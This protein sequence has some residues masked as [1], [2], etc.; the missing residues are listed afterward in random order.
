MIQI[1]YGPGTSQGIKDLTERHIKSSECNL[2]ETFV[3]DEPFTQLTADDKRLKD[4]YPNDFKQDSQAQAFFLNEE[5]GKLLIF[6]TP[7]REQP[8]TY[9]FIRSEKD[10]KHIIELWPTLPTL[11]QENC[12]P[13]FDAKNIVNPG[14]KAALEF[15]TTARITTDKAIGLMVLCSQDIDINVIAQVAR[16][17]Y[18]TVQFL[19]EEGEYAKKLFAA[20][21][22]PEVSDPDLT[23][24]NPLEE[25][26]GYRFSTAFHNWCLKPRRLAIFHKK[27]DEIK[28]PDAQRERM[29]DHLFPK[30]I[31][32]RIE[33]TTHCIA[34]ALSL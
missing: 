31:F 13:P 18:H 32:A 23:F 11:Y 28:H 19:Q 17:K 27:L 4:F 7:G 16:A 1:E 14:G 30:E 26:T 9:L 22:H 3:V 20:A 33:Y 12:T 34:Y 21:Y 5:T 2:P 15:T 25:G 8:I 10:G 29:K 6:N 24:D